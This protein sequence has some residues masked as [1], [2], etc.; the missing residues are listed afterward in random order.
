MIVILKSRKVE[1]CRDRIF[2]SC[3]DGASGVVH[4]ERFAVRVIWCCCW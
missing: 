1:Y 4:D 3:M 2:V